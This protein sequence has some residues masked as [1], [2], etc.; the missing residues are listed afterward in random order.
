MTF[1]P[2]LTSLSSYNMQENKGDLHQLVFER[3]LVI[4][5]GRLDLAS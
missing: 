3:K 5:F 2:K 1:N 4:G